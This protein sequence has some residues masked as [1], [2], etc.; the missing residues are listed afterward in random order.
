MYAYVCGVKFYETLV[1]RRSSG[2]IRHSST[3]FTVNSTSSSYCSTLLEY[4][5]AR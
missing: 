3:G 2:L 5:C 1:V 4:E